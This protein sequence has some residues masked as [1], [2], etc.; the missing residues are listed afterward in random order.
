[1]AIFGALAAPPA[2]HAHASLNAGSS[3]ANPI[4]TNGAIA[5]WMPATVTVP[6]IGYLGM[7][8]ISNKRVIQTGLYTYGYAATNTVNA[9]GVITSG[10]AGATADQLG[11]V[12]GGA[13]PTVGDTLQG[14][15]RKYNEV[16]NTPGST[17]SD[18]PTTGSISVG[19]NSWA[20][21]VSDSNSGLSWGNLHISS[22]TG[23][24]E[25]NL[26]PTVKYVNVTVGDDSLFAGVNQLA[27]SIYQGWATGPGMQGLH[28]LGTALASTLGQDIGISIALSGLTLNGPGTEGQYT[29]VV[30]DQTS[31]GAF[32]GHYKIGLE[33]SLTNRYG[34]IVSAV[35]VPG[36]VWLFGSAMAGLIGFGRRK[37]TV[38]A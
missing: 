10:P 13:T 2:A 19:Q 21:G 26:M 9:D 11:G 5:D 15:L 25:A 33:A 31:S 34:N 17:T 6:S 8:G 28:L 16:T 20:A 23:N 37:E 35:P 24:P 30:G 4:W 1:M 36:A 29:I 27:F 22:G 7:H 38:A 14:Q 12:F 32:D 3:G 18:L